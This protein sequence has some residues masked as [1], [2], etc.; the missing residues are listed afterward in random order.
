MHSTKSG[1][2]P[3]N[4]KVIEFK[5]QFRIYLFIFSEQVSRPVSITP[6]KPSYGPWK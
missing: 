6:S 1:S 2:A 4:F 3:A 5:K